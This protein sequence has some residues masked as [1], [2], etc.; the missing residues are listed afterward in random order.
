MKFFIDTAD[1]D[2]IREAASWGVLS[3]VT[4]NPSLYARTG[5]RLADFE[6]HVVRICEACEGLP[7]SAESTAETTEGMVAEGRRLAALA[8][9]VVVKLPVCEESLPACHAL[10]AEGVR[11]NMTLV[12]SAPQ[13]LLAA[14][15]GARYVSPFVGRFDDVADDGLAQLETVVDAVRNYDYGWW[16]E[17]GGPEIIAASVRTPNHVTQAA[18]MG[19]DIATVPLAA[20][21]RCV[22][23]PLTSEGLA[24]FAADWKKVTEG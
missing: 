19:A 20:L 17:E 9:N 3:G 18:L 5:G 1:L 23:H 2:E 24:K 6:P 12:F 21:R 8:P 16:D 4:T 22:R 14:R 7:V 13:A 10:A 15:A 11:V